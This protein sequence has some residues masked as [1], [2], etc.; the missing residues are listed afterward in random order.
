MTTNKHYFLYSPEEDNQG[1]NPYAEGNET[2]QPMFQVQENADQQRTER[3][4]WYKR[5]RE[6]LREWSAG[7]EEE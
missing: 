4:P 6:A 7:E 5:I 1:G 2:E 3:K